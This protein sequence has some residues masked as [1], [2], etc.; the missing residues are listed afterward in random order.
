MVEDHQ[1]M[2][3]G[4]WL[5]VRVFA[6]DDKQPLHA[7]RVLWQRRGRKGTKVMRLKPIVLP[8]VDQEIAPIV[9]GD[10]VLGVSHKSVYGILLDIDFHNLRADNDYDIEFQTR[11]IDLLDVFAG[12]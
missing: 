7:I 6:I 9:S 5:V 11:A 4:L 12:A 10:W 1:F 2:P 3:T 8:V